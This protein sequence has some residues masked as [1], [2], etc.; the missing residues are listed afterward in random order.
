LTHARVYEGLDKSGKTIQIHT[1]TAGG[2]TGVAHLVFI[3]PKD[4]YSDYAQQFEAL[5]GSLRLF[6][7]SPSL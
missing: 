6:L 1:Y 2:L 7:T 3:A 4:Q 5:L